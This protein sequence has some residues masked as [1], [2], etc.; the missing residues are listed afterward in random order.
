MPILDIEAEKTTVNQDLKQTFQAQEPVNGPITLD[1]A[2]ARAIKYN[3]NGQISRMEEAL[4]FGL[5]EQAKYEMLP[6]L[7]TQAGYNIRNSEDGSISKVL[8]GANAGTITK[9]YSTSTDK[10]VLTNDLQLVWNFLDFGVAYLNAQDQEQRYI[11]ATH[12][13]R[14]SIQNLTTQVQTAYWKA[15]AAQTYLPKLKKLILQAERSL[16]Q[17]RT[18]QQQQVQPP[19]RAL[20][21]QQTLLESLENLINLSSD[22]EH[23]QQDLTQLI[24]LPPGSTYQLADE[25][26]IKS[27]EPFTPSSLFPDNRVSWMEEQALNRHADL[28]Q[29]ELELSISSNAIRKE[30]FSLFPGLTLQGGTHLTTNQFTYNPAWMNVGLT[31]AWNA[32]NV[33]SAPERINNAKQRHAI[34]RM[35]RLNNAMSILTQVHLSRQQYNNRYE[36]LKI[37]NDLLHIQQ[38][39]SRITQVQIEAE[40]TTA[41]Q[42]TQVDVNTLFAEI[43]RDLAYA[44]MNNALGQLYHT[45]GMDP[46][47]HDVP[48]TDLT[49]LTHFIRVQREQNRYTML[50]NAKN[51]PQLLDNPLGTSHKRK[52]NQGAYSIQ[53]GVYQSAETAQVLATELKRQGY[54]PTLWK[55][56]WDDGTVWHHVIMGHYQQKRHAKMLATDLA[57]RQK[58]PSLIIR[59]PRTPL[60]KAP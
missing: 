60:A 12:Q 59:I 24:N 56:Y 44:E 19:M 51:Q 7:T 36:K 28:W 2:I 22:L 50:N 15:V 17:S 8:S 52:R 41:Q 33:L 31:L 43:K 37:A 14:K 40:A 25:P 3:L 39:K 11:I 9:D 18:L 6:Q 35:K 23:S 48:T 5:R 46:V 57:H 32:L 54:A 1:E 38:T 53:I 16:K 29:S 20:E 45:L 47:S 49:T 10:A 4:Q 58:I 27:L 34:T 55:E 42:Q 21:Y 30:L 26:K 13:R